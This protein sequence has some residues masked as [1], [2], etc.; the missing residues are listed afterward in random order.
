MRI[1]AAG[2]GAASQTFR[3]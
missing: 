2:T 3:L 1:R